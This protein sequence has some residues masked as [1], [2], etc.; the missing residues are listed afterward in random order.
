MHCSC[1]GSRAPVAPIDD[2]HPAS[3]RLMWRL[4]PS[5]RADE[6]GDG[7]SLYD[8]CGE[9]GTGP[10]PPEL[11]CAWSDRSTDTEGETIHILGENK[12]RPTYIVKD[13]LDIFLASRREIAEKWS[14]ALEEGRVSG[15]CPIPWDVCDLGF[16]A[17]VVRPE[18]RGG[19]WCFAI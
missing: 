14:V 3:S 16:T 2:P 13:E 17:Q 10:T 9:G 8:S 6:D 15:P 7:W 5:E 1:G 18:N 19:G 11:A 4:N 12:P